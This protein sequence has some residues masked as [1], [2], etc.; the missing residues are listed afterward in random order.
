MQVAWAAGA[1]QLHLKA[2]NRTSSSSSPM[3]SPDIL[4]GGVCLQQEVVSDMVNQEYKYFLTDCH[5][6]FKSLN[7]SLV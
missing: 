7:K 4:K 3:H 5:Q 2:R 6:S 1:G